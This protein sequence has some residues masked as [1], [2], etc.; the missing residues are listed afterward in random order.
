L[1]EYSSAYLSRNDLI[2]LVPPDISAEVSGDPGNPRLDH[3]LRRTPSFLSAPVNHVTRKA[4]TRARQKPMA[5][6]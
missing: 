2:G 5:K 3:N 4:K 1:R 6:P